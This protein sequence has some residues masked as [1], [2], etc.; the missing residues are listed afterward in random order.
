MYLPRG[1]ALADHVWTLTVRIFD[2]YWSTT[3]VVLRAKIGE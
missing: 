1:P 3:V 2:I